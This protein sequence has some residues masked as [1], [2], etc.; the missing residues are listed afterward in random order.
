MAVEK[1][2]ASTRG[3]AGRFL[4]TGLHQTAHWESAYGSN[5]PNGQLGSRNRVSIPKIVWGENAASIT[6][7]TDNSA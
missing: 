7:D 3:F 6:T 5:S 2:D 4:A 1:P